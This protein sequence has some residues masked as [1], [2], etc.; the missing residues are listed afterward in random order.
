MRRFEI[1]FDMM[2]AALFCLLTLLLLCGCG[3]G[4][5][6][7]DPPPVAVRG[8]GNRENSY[9]LYERKFLFEPSGRATVLTHAIL[10]VGSE[11]ME[12]TLAAF[13]G[14]M[15][16]LTGYEARIVYADGSLERHTMGDLASSTLSSSRMIAERSVRHVG[17]E[18]IPGPG[19]LV[20]SVA[21]HELS[22]PQLGIHFSPAEAG[23]RVL[24]AAC[25]IEIPRG[26]TILTSLLNDSAGTTPSITR[27]DQS[28]VYRFEWHQYRKNENPSRFAR[29]NEAPQLFAI[30]SRGPQSWQEFGDWY[31]GVISGKLK[32][33]A[34]IAAAAK[35]IVNERMSPRDRMFAV[36]RY[37]QS[38]IRYE[39]VYLEGGEI[40]PNDAAVIF[41][42][43]YGDCKDYSTLMAVLAR[44]AG[45]NPDLVLCWRGGGHAFC[46][47]LPVNQFNHMIIHWEDGEKE[48]WFDGT[49]PPEA[50]GIASDDLSNARALILKPGGS[51][52]ATMQESPENLLSVSGKFNVKGDDLLGTMTIGLRGQYAIPFLGAARQANLHAAKAGLSRWIE[53]SVSSGVT[54][55]DLLWNEDGPAFFVKAACRFPN[56]L[57][58]AGNSE[59]IRFDKIFNKLLPQDEPGLDSADVFYYPG[60]ARVD[61][62]VTI[63]DFQSPSGGD[64]R[65]E[66]HLALPSGPFDDTTRGDFLTKY[67]TESA[68]ASKVMQ[69]QRKG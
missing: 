55:S 28:T 39:Q 2:R 29:H 64:F 18:R 37:C 30:P 17:L 60:Y 7:T 46:D 38:N 5:M 45:L 6:L 62:D 26:D 14:S 36:A 54:I 44:E 32:A 21:E 23:D 49:N 34:Q 10:V 69:V 67:K 56:A 68:R 3:G 16:R 9:R 8:E 41:R 42:H 4:R 57:W 12:R 52:L 20:E 35:T 11:G 61:V 43:R 24:L 19:D 15:M 59:H 22:L 51:H 66:Y 27:N 31:L 47:K 65:W 33:D 40:I 48:Y 25:V 63:P 50:I 13:D 58:H 1:F 53:Q